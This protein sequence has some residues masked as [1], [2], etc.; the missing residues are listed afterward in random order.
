M[1]GAEYDGE[2][3]DDVAEAVAVIETRIKQP[4]RAAFSG[5]GQHTRLSETFMTGCR[6]A[7]DSRAHFTAC[8]TWR[9]AYL[10]WTME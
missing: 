10:G 3:A 8:F 2:S 7:S 5:L 1:L 6:L 4:S 9:A